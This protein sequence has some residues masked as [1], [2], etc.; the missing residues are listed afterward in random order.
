MRPR[1]A[2]LLLVIVLFGL[3]LRLYGLDWDQGHQAHPDERY[4]AWVTASLRPPGDAQGAFLNPY[5]WPSGAPRP[6]SYGH[7]PLYLQALLAGGADDE[8]IILAGRTLSALFDTATILLTF[9][10]GRALYGERVGLLGA[11]FLA[12]T[13]SHIQQAHFAT[14]DAIT[15]TWVMAALLLS[16]YWLRGGRP[17]LTLGSGVCAGLAIGSK[18]SAFLVL[19]PLVLAHWLRREGLDW[20]R[21]RWPLIWLALSLLA[22]LLAFAATNPFALIEFDRFVAGL[23]TQSQ[24]LQGDEQVPFTQQYHGTL[25]YLYP[26][27]QQVR[28]GMGLPLG[29]VAVAGLI[30]ALYRAWR[31]PPRPEEW[32]LLAWVV[33]YFGLVGGLPVKF[34]RYMLPLSPALAIYGAQL[35]NDSRIASREWRPSRTLAPPHRAARG[36]GVTGSARDTQHATR[37]LTTLILLSTSLYALVVVNVYRGEHPWLRA[38]RWVYRNVPPGSRLALEAWDEPLPL[39]LVAENPGWH[40]ER[41]QVQRLDWYAPDTPNKL[42]AALEQ[43]ADS[44]YV[45]IASQRVYRAT[46]G[47]PQRYP[48]TC[49]YYQLLFGGELGLELRVFARRYPALGPLALTHN[50]FDPVG[51]PSP[52]PPDARRPRAIT[53]DL[54]RADESFSVYDHPLP[55]IFENVGRLTPVEMEALFADLLDN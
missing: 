24:M 20:R 3:A 5:R 27:E 48:L 31:R 23:R 50:P 17:A 19:L 22:A 30:Y 40:I 11:A 55:L 6:F 9:G 53:L 18:F 51:L 36:A 34:M 21:L 39:R 38:S 28:W 16:A 46:C 29:L 33:L 37:L 52:L 42:E 8:G 41:Y 44:D 7:F 15:T 14:Y 45:I 47:W 32:V 2:L 25:P 4:V 26:L 43:L 54:G 1:T 49:R 13:V 12:L 35:L 10:L